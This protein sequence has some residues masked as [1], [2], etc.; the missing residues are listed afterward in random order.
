MVYF[1]NNIP[2]FGCL[3]YTTKRTTKQ[4]KTIYKVFYIQLF[5]LMPH[6]LFGLIWVHEGRSFICVLTSQHVTKNLPNLFSVLRSPISK[7]F[8]MACI[9]TSPAPDSVSFL[10]HPRARTAVPYT[11]DIRG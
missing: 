7:T 11:L 4:D 8:F 1:H 3:L 6:S 9:P 2:S 10:C 5:T